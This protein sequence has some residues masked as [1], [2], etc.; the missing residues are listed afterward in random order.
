MEVQPRARPTKKAMKPVVI[1]HLHSADDAS[2]KD[3][4]APSDG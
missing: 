4:V 3:G 2:W 1:H